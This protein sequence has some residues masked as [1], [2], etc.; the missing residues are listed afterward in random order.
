MDTAAKYAYHDLKD[1]MKDEADA[2][3]W[4]R[5]SRWRILTAAVKAFPKSAA[6]WGAT[7]GAAILIFPGLH[8]LVALF[9]TAGAGAALMALGAAFLSWRRDLW[10]ADGGRLMRKRGVISHCEYSVIPENITSVEVEQSPLTALFR[11][12]RLSCRTLGEKGEKDDILLLPT[13]ELRAVTGGLAQR[14]RGFMRRREA[15]FG[16]LLIFALSGWETPAFALAALPA[17]LFGD[18]GRRLLSEFFAGTLALFGI[19]PVLM[20]AGAAWTFLE[21]WRF[22]MERTDMAVVVRRGLI[23]RRSSRIP[24]DMIFA[25][26]KSS[27][28]L[29]A[30]LSRGSVYALTGGR[31]RFCLSLAANRS[32]SRF[33]IGVL[34]DCG[35][36]AVA[37]S[38]EGKA[39]RGYYLWWLLAS[40]ASLSFSIK[41]LFYG[42]VVLGSALLAVSLLLLARGIAGVFA[43]RSAGVELYA[44]RVALH[45][46]RLFS[47][48]SIFVRRKRVAIVRIRQWP[49]QRPRGLCTIYIRPAGSSSGLG[50]AGLSLSRATAVAERLCMGC[51]PKI[52]PANEKLTN[53]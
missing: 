14:G 44:C 22:R 29:Q 52:I 16:E 2:R 34:P 24:L 50:C 46:V 38:P 39:R 12:A 41:P 31:G 35:S 36:R 30:L 13:A 48:K 26:E 43:V 51:S 42:N 23:R 28:I 47:I 49:H 10:R 4:S 33:S 7:A 5:Q 37:A 27:T 25:L 3:A 11:A 20:I 32:E 40:A 53:W 45:G 18:T 21:F 9:G 1:R 15:S 19:V 17:L 6:L 8:G